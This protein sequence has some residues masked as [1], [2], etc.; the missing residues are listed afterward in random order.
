MATRFKTGDKS[1]NRAWYNWDGY[2]DGTSSPAPTQEEQRIPLETVKPSPRYDP[3][4]RARIGSIL[5][6]GEI[7]LAA[8]LDI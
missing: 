2:T 7:A 6:A 3:A 1:P 5:Q 4:T 8:P